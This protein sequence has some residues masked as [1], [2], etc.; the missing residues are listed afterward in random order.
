VFRPDSGLGA[1][2]ARTFLLPSGPLVVSIV[3]ANVGVFSESVAGGLILVS[4]AWFFCSLIL[5]PAL[6]FRDD[7]SPGSSTDDDGGGSGG[8][9]APPSPDPGPGG[10]PLPDAEQSRERVR[11]HVRRKRQWLSRREW[12]KTPS[13]V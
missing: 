2:V 1:R 6:L 4:G 8:P 12:E 9:S 10:I 3:L 11:D 5:V 13:R 7:F